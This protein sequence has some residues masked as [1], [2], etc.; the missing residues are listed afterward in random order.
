MAIQ[1]PKHIKKY[2]DHYVIGQNAAKEAVSSALF[3]HH[4]RYFYDHTPTEGERGHVPRQ[5]VLILGPSGSGKSYIVQKACEY[6]G[7]PYYEIP[8]L[9]I[10]PDGWSGVGI[11]RH[12]ANFKQQYYGRYPSAETARLEMRYSVIF[13]DEID[14]ICIP[15]GSSNS[16]DFNLL[17]QHNLLKLLEGTTYQVEGKYD[18]RYSGNFCP[19]REGAPVYEE[20]K[21]HNVLFICAGHFGKV[22]EQKQLL[23]KPGIGFKTQ[24]ADEKSIHKLITGAGMIPELLG[25]LSLV[26]ET[27]VLTKEQVKEVLTNASD[28]IFKQYQTLFK[29]LGHKLELTPEEEDKIVDYCFDQNIGV[30]G[31]AHIVYEVLKDRIYNLGG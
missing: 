20:F 15:A 7:A 30:R 17:K 2:L 27:R 13:I 28:N 3:M 9:D 24:V 22:E 25:R 1:S 23:Q 21:T 11:R 29:H 16:G 19:S 4:V 8:A 31:L 5:N 18:S 6:L 26:T 10:A 12:L 14:K